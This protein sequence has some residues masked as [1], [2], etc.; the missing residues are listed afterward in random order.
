M[1]RE[2]FLTGL[3]GRFSLHHVVIH[4][5]FPTQEDPEYSGRLPGL[6]PK[7]G[8][9]VTIHPGGHE[10]IPKTKL[11]SYLLFIRLL[12]QQTPR[13]LSS[14]LKFGEDKG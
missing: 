10:Y 4:D 6:C 1:S 11:M 12:K 5:Y 2:I 13:H 9:P 7:A 14:S 3:G 8:G